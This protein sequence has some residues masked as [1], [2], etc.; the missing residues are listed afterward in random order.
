LQYL[1]ANGQT[2]ELAS[3][4]ERMLGVARAMGFFVCDCG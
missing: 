3:Y 4:D 1:V 2:M